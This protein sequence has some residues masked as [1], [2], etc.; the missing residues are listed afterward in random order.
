MPTL[1]ACQAEARTQ[2][3]GF[4]GGQAPHTVGR[5][6]LRQGL[7]H[8]LPGQKN[9]ARLSTARSL[10]QPWAHRSATSQAQPAWHGSAKSRPRPENNRAAALDLARP[11][12]TPVVLKP[13][14][15]RPAATA[16]HA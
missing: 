2:L 4:D 3:Q 15:S 14:A 1:A 5:Y 11:G 9:G 10:Q 16:H 7:L 6:R 13:N 8:R 12:V